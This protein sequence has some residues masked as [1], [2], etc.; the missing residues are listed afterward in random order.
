MWGA[1]K[2]ETA[3]YV[4]VFLFLPAIAYIYLIPWINEQRIENVSYSNTTAVK[5]KRILYWTP[6]YSSTD[7]YF[8]FGQQ[9][10]LNKCKQSAGFT[11]V[12]CETTSNRSLLN[13]SDAV[14]FHIRDLNYDDIPKWRKPDQIWIFFLMESPQNTNRPAARQLDGIFNWT[15][16][17]RRDSDVPNAYFKVIK[18]PN[19]IEWNATTMLDNIIK[20]KKRLAAWLVSNCYPKNHRQDIVKKLQQFIPIDVYGQCGQPCPGKT[21]KECLDF[22]F[23]NYKFYLAFENSLCKDYLT[24]K[25][26]NALKANAVPIVYGGADYNAIA[27]PNSFI[28]IK[29]FISARELANYI[30]NINASQTLYRNYFQWKK[31]YQIAPQNSFC[32]LCEKLHTTDLADEFNRKTYN[33]MTRWWFDQC[34]MDYQNLT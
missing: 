26:S 18:Q 10:F 30:L 2:L 7:Y 27:P 3:K 31:F 5:T 14:I 6:F 8:G 32:H 21:S 9:P 15:M 34:T 17:Y 29:N 12:Q 22:I 24:E 4:L 25:F 13:S 1:Y 20:K 33:N 23:S 11:K 28:N 19:L 16:T